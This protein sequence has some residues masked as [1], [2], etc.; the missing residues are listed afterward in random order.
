VS[1]WPEFEARERRWKEWAERRKA[2]ENPHVVRLVETHTKSV[3]GTLVF[4]PSGNQV[5]TVKSVD[6]YL[7]LGE[8]MTARIETSRKNLWGNEVTEVITVPVRIEVKQP[9]GN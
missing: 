2:S 7:R 5:E 4:D 8:G 1:F 3:Q 6:F 9:C